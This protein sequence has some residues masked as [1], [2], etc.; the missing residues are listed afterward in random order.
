MSARAIPRPDATPTP[1]EFV[2]VEKSFGPLVVLRGVSFAVRAGA[3]HFVIGPSGAG[4]SVLI[5]Q[6]VGL[7]RPDGGEVRA[8]GQS[9]AGLDDDGLR[10]VRRRCQ[11]IFQHPTLFEQLTV[12]DNVAMPIAKRFRASRGEAADRARQALSRVG[13][14]SYAARFPAELGKGVQKRVSVARAIALEPEVLLYDEPTTSLDPVA[15]RRM[16]RLIRGMA[17]AL[18]VTSVVVSHD[19]VSV[20]D[21]A[22][23]VTVLLGGTARFDGT[24]QGLF[25]SGDPEVHE[26][27]AAGFLAATS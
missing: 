20:R 6:V 8:F 2:A 16:D 9:V 15:A 27:V 17:D 11:M 10:A 23:R 25:Q 12:Q 7:L 13:A 19:V 3:V 4:K 14:L 1:L 24:T 18:G 22:D 21:I 26:F 5:K